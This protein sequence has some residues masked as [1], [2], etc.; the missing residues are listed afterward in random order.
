MSVLDPAQ[1]TC[2]PCVRESDNVNFD[3]PPRMSDGR[4]FTDYRARCDVNLQW[5]KP[6]DS[7]YDYR[8][9][10]IGNA[11]SLMDGQRGA[12]H[13]KAYCGPCVKPYDQGTVLP[14]KDAFVCDKVGCRKEAGAQGGIGTGRDYGMIPSQKEALDAFLAQQA[15]QQAR[16]EDSA[17][18]CACGPNGGGAYPLPGMNSTGQ[19]PQDAR[20]AMPSGGRPLGGTDARCT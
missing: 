19:Q 16:L 12:A 15:S 14:E 1:R 10:L 4:L 6:M 18:C 11:E 7:S 8:Q 13:A 5:Q 20:W 17:N 2:G 3:C 9:F